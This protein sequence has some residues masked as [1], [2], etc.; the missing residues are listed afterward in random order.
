MN[1]TELTY[2][3]LQTELKA[4]K[5]RGYQV[6]ALNSKRAVLEAALTELIGQQPA[7]AAPSAEAT[8]LETVAQLAAAGNTPPAVLADILTTVSKKALLAHAQTLGIKGL[9]KLNKLE[10]ALAIIQQ[11]PTQA[12]LEA[13]ILHTATQLAATGTPPAILADILTTVS[14][15][16]LLAHAKTLHIQGVH[17]ISKFNLALAIAQHR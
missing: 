16:A 17:R 7:T 11:P 9:S 1:A 15:Q 13:S 14:K 10:L 12:A 6:P 3:Q 5:A 8:I 4:L 2:R